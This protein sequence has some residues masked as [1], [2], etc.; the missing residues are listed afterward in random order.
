MWVQFL[1][2]CVRQV[3]HHHNILVCSCGEDQVSN[4]VTQQLECVL[5]PTLFQVTREAFEP[6]EVYVAVYLRK[7]MAQALRR[8]SGQCALWPGRVTES[9][10]EP[11]CGDLAEL[12]RATTWY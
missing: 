8:H 6:C 1:R 7:N 5:Q 10:R 3:H 11:N 12:R 2:E 4:C 9:A